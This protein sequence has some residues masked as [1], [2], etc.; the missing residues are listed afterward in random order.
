MKHL[1]LSLL[2]TA[3]LFGT[4][5]GARV[6]ASELRSN[7]TFHGLA[8]LA[9]SRFLHNANAM[10]Q[11]VSGSEDLPDD[12]AGTDNLLLVPEPA[13]RRFAKS[14]INHVDS[15]LFRHY[16]IRAPPCFI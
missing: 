6:E 11:L 15:L 9:G 10:P 3:S 12:L 13:S 2:L 7:D 4:A 16:A 1:L 14:G 8:H 5:H